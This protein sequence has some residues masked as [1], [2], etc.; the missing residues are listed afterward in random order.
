M[1]D[2]DALLVA[3]ITKAA[4]TTAGDILVASG[5]STP[6]RLGVGANGTVLTVA[7]GAPVWQTPASAVQQKVAYVG[8]PAVNGPSPTAWP[9]AS[10]VILVPFTLQTAQTIDRVHFKT[11]GTQSGNFDVGVYDSLG[12]RV[13]SKGSTA[14]STLT[15][16]ALNE[17][18]FTSTPL[19]AGQY[20]LAFAA[21]NVTG[22]FVLSAA[23]PLSKYQL[24]VATSFPLPATLTPGTAHPTAALL[25]SAP[26]T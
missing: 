4:Y 22:A 5:A 1:S 21:D 13:V 16:S 23:D 11:G 12:N 10:A 9:T 18:T 26:V 6:A 15:V 2:I 8:M 24:Q 3:R 20:Y 14:Q 7:G 19:A 17:V 25:L